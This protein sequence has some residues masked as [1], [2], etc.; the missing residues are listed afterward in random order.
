MT[1]IGFCRNVPFIVSRIYSIK[2]K[3]F[4][5]II[6]AFNFNVIARSI[7][8]YYFNSKTKYF[9]IG[10]VAGFYTKF[11]KINNKTL[12]DYTL[13]TKILSIRN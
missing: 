13:K 1:Y 3:I 9:G 12:F 11:K 10:S 5:F 8:G 4:L 7:S 6:L 2:R